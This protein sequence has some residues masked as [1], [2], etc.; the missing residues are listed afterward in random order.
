MTLLLEGLRWGES[1]AAWK[2]GWPLKELGGMPNEPWPWAYPASSRG[3]AAVPGM[4]T[5]QAAAA[6]ATVPAVEAA[7][8]LLSDVAGASCSAASA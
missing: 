7:D 5:A 3:E 4:S 8:G 2:S 1:D 6:A